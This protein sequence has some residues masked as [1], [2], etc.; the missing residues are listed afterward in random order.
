MKTCFVLLRHQQHSFCFVMASRTW[1]LF[2][3]GINNM[4]IVLFFHLQH[5][6]CFVLASS[7][8]S[9]H[10][11]HDSWTMTLG[12]SNGINNMALVLFWHQQQTTSPW[13][14]HVSSHASCQGHISQVSITSRQ[15]NEG[16]QRIPHICHR[17][18]RHVCVKKNCPV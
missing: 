18:H 13:N 15:A 6:F 2:C 4:L 8:A 16:T 1:L 7:I 9:F 5:G 12:K 14:T 10:S 11:I 17:H 3:F